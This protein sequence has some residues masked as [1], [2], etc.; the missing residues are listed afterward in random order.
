[1]HLKIDIIGSYAT[2]L[3][4]PYSDIDVVFTNQNSSYIQIEETLGKIFS[5]LKSRQRELGIKEIYFNKNN[6]G[7]SFPNIKMD[8]EQKLNY[9]KIDITIFQKKNNGQKYVRFIAERLYYNPFLKPVFFAVHK[10]LRSYDLAN[11]AKN[12]L[13][14]YAIFLMVLLSAERCKAMS[15]GELF[16]N[17][18]Y[19]YAHYFLYEEQ[20]DG[21]SKINIYDPLN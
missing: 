8:L 20:L 1:M 2:G 3:W 13:K 14:T 18:I 16:I 21:T 19:F 11:P 7:N 15:S 4:T 6:N 10:L 17:T 12:G 9:R 5:V